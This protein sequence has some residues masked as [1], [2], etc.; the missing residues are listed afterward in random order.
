MNAPIPAFELA[1]YEFAPG[2]GGKEKELEPPPICGRCCW[3]GGGSENAFIGVVVAGRCW[4]IDMLFKEL[5][6]LALLAQG[7]GAAAA[8]PQLTDVCG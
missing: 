1:W 7:F 8:A 6:L 2:G 5:E 4:F 3:P